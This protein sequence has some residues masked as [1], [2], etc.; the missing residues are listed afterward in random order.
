MD[1]AL[2]RLRIDYAVFCFSSNE[3]YCSRFF[4]IKSLKYKQLTYNVSA[5]VDGLFSPSYTPEGF[6]P[7][8]SYSS[9]GFMRS[10]AFDF[11]HPELPKTYS[12]P[13]Y[14]EEH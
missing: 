5:K 8:P 13:H 2:A 14:G 12:L 6:C 1:F 9:N 3:V 11:I 4:Q 7:P 10:I